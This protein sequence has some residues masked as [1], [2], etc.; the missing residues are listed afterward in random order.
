MRRYLISIYE[1]TLLVALVLSTSLGAEGAILKALK[2]GD[3]TIAMDEWNP[4]SD[5]KRIV[6]K[7]T[8]K[9]TSYWRC[10]WYEGKINKEISIKL[11]DAEQGDADAQFYLGRMYEEGRY[12]TK[13]YAKSFMWFNVATKENPKFKFYRS[14]IEKKM[15]PQQITKGLRLTDDWMEKYKK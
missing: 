2:G 7:L 4:L 14:K 1:L 5:R 13:D 10:G 15:S 12:V 3:H 9:G 8:Q 6:S 11:K